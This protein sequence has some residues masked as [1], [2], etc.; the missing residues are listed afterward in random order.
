MT[1]KLPIVWGAKAIGDVIRR[2]E[3]QTHYLLERG[4]IRA[5]RKVGL[6]GVRVCR[7]CTRSFATLP[8]AAPLNR[9]TPH[10]EKGRAGRTARP[11][12]S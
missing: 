4:A 9:T 7:G 10:K 5:A 2:T 3:H 11:P 12:D 6:N 1:D 8:S